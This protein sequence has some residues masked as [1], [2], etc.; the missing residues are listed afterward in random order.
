M[1][2]HVTTDLYFTCY[3]ISSSNDMGLLPK[4]F[5]LT[6]HQNKK[7]EILDILYIGTTELIS[8]MF[9]LCYQVPTRPTPDKLFYITSCKWES[10][11]DSYH[12]NF[13]FHDNDPSKNRNWSADRGPPAAF[14]AIKGLWYSSQNESPILNIRITISCTTSDGFHKCFLV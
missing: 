8:G 12:P 3:K 13:N 10:K 1:Y 14:H 7:F 2:Y 4:K 9:S 6:Y 11:N 5:H